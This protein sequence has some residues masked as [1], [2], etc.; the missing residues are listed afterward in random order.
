MA[1]PEGGGNGPL[2]SVIT[3][4]WNHRDEL[5]PYLAA[6]EKTRDKLPFQ[7]E[8]VIVDNDSTDGTADY[9]ESRSPWVRVVRKDTNTGFAEGCNIGFREARGT[10]F[11]LL[12]PDAMA[13]A[14]ALGGMVKYLEDNPAVGAVGCLL[15]HEDGLPQFSAY[16]PM[17][18]I[19]YLL[20]QSM[21]YPVVE[22][23]RKILWKAGF[24]R[25]DKP[26]KCG[27]L[28]GSCIVVP[29]AVWEQVG[30]FDAS[31]FMYCEDTDWC[32]RIRMAGHDVV[33]LPGLRMI[34]VQKGSSRRAAEWCFRR[35]YRSNLHFANLHKK[36]LSRLLFRATMLADMLVRVPVY[37][38]LSVVL[39]GKGPFLRG[40]TRSV[41]RMIR[42]VWAG[43]PDTFDDPPPGRSTE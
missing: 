24:M 4:T 6:L 16:A 41:V 43:D 12:N 21:I 19:P 25:S 35:V 1:K 30:G 38:V 9:I 23:A 31:Y 42:I 39:P 34:H 5:E 13:T 10:Y 26:R 17:G 40:R 11:M 32:H 15:V 37:M 22:K 27:W 33:F 29:R 20:N 18:P 7:L 3:V 14:D 28:M 8:V 36:G 2:L